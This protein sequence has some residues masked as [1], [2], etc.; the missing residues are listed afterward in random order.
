[1]S[2]IYVGNLSFD[3]NEEHLREAFAAYNPAAVTIVMDRETG[4]S[5]GF[6]F[7]SCENAEMANEA[8]QASIEL[9]GR[10]LK[11]DMARPPSES[12]GSGN[13]FRGRP[14]NRFDGNGSRSNRY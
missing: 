6:G 8:V 4:R 10:T 1:M 3:T 14:N 9:N 13:N 7:V 2:K 11:I 12:R 5:K